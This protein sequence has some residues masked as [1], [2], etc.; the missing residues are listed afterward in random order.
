[1]KTKAPILSPRRVSS[2]ADLKPK[3]AFSI[4]LRPEL[5]QDSLCPHQTPGCGANC[6]ADN[7]PEHCSYG[8]PDAAPDASANACSEPTAESLSDTVAEP[9]TDAPALRF[10]VAQAHGGAVVSAESRPVSCANTI[11]I[12]EDNSCADA[13]SVL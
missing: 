8:P 12:T 5:I 1:M 2:D 13:H 6:T 11:A 4:A 10:A 3:L 9:A 7:E